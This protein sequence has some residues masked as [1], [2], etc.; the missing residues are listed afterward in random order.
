MVGKGNAGDLGN[1]NPGPGQYEN[2]NAIYR[3]NPSWKIGTSQRD[4]ELKRVKREGVPGPGNYEFDDKTKNPVIHIMEEQKQ[5]RKKGGTM[6]L[7][8]YPCKLKEGTLASKVYGKH[9]LA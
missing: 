9:E 8:S 7:G 6:R 4:D 5:I 1:K 2:S 3:K